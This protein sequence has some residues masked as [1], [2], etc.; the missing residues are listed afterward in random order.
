VIFELDG[1][2]AHQRNFVRFGAIYPKWQASSEIGAKRFP[3]EST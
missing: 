2:D 1:I 3:L